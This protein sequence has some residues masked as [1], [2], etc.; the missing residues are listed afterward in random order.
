MK[1]KANKYTD[2]SYSVFLTDFTETKRNLVQILIVFTIQPEQTLI[3][4]GSAYSQYQQLDAL[5]LETSM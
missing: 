5:Q 4:T 2:Q 1:Q 3:S